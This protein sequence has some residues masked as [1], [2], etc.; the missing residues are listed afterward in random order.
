MI[1]VNTAQALI[2]DQIEALETES[3]VLDECVGR[4]LSADLKAQYMLPG[5]DNSA[6][7][8]FAI[9]F[10]DLH[11]ENQKL[12]ITDEIAAGDGQ[13]RPLADLSAARVFTGALIPPGADT[14]IIQENCTITDDEVQIQRR[15][16]RGANIRRRGSDLNLGDTYLRRGRV[17]TAGDISLASSQGQS[18]LPVHRRANVSIMTTGNELIRPEDA[19]PK[20]GQIIDSNSIALAS[21]VQEMGG[22]SNR[23]GTLKDDPD[24]ILA[25]LGASR[26]DVVITTGGAS[27]GKFDFIG[28]AIDQ[29][30]QDGFGFRKVAVKPGKPVIF[31]RRGRQ[32]FFGLPGNPVSAL[33]AFEL[34]VRPALR[35]LHGHRSIFRRPMK[36]ILDSPL[37]SG[38]RRVEYR[39]GRCWN[40]AGTLFVRVEEKQSSGAMSTIAAQDVLLRVEVD[41]NALD[42]GTQVHVLPLHDELSYREDFKSG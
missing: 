16:K 40:R 30:C 8:G 14:V 27:V 5:W 36:A 4:V 20:R 1:S 39:R 22:L 41:Q 13:I 28:H 35:K 32:L 34:F 29:I 11:E 17:V 23:D 25:K 38:G 19:P 3:C 24:A 12:T 18:V 6:M 2:L 37:Q 7:D 21:C 10:S 42:A 15:P 31:G 26:A 9:R 33:V